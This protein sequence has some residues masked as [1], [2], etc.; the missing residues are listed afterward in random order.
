MQLKTVRL[1]AHNLR[2]E[3]ASRLK[4]QFLANMSHEL[5][6]PL[7]TIIGFSDV[8]HRGLTGA[9]S[10]QQREFL[11]DILASSKHL[12]QLINDVLDLAKVEAGKLEFAPEPVEIAPLVR[13]VLDTLRGL[14]A[15][16][17]LRMN[18]TIHAEVSTVMIDPARV[19]Q[20]LYN[21]ISNAIKFTPEDGAIEISVSR[22]DLDLFRID[23]TDTGGGIPAADLGKLF[24]D[25]QQLDASSAKKHQG[26]GLGLA[27]TKRL[28]EAQGGWVDVCSVVGEGSTFSAILPY[29]TTTAA[30]Q[31]RDSS[32]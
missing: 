13:E 1:E 32:V 14:A 10:D 26:T 22:Q 29:V 27:L 5:R 28:T 8:M 3:S 15:S 6:T 30:G 18:A 2:I 12:L 9:M 11:G 20:I 19:K 23:V 21:Y 7:N 17:R 4:S 31:D 24:V 16:K 25:F